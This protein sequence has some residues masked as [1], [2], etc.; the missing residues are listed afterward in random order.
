MSTDL[1]PAARLTLTRRL[2]EGASWADYEPPTQPR[3]P[4]F[5]A[6]PWRPPAD[7]TCSPDEPCLAHDCPTCARVH[8]CP[9]KEAA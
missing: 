3:G 2:P 8:G 5:D 6:D 9:A 7:C 4:G 1:P